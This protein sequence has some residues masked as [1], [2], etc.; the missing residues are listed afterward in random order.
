MLILSSRVT[1]RGRR[2][3]SQLDSSCFTVDTTV[4]LIVF[5]PNAPNCNGCVSCCQNVLKAVSI[6]WPNAGI[7]RSELT[8]YLRVV[9]HYGHYR[10]LL[11][12][13]VLCYFCDACFADSL[14]IYTEA[15]HSSEMSLNFYQF[16][17]HK[18]VLFIISV[19]RN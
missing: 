13:L 1:L 11:I 16:T 3:S 10:N 6:H 17:T 7:F 12:L 18:I 9:I 5:N 19:M 14:T 4:P 8:R 15:V 2:S